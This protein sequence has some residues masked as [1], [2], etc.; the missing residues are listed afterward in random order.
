MSSLS[1]I[2]PALGQ[3]L[4][5][6]ARNLSFDYD[7]VR[8][9]SDLTIAVP[10]GEMFGF[11]GPNG[12]GKSTVLSLLAGLYTPLAGS[13]CVL[14]RSPDHRLRSR[15]GVLFQDSCLDS[16]M[17]VSETLRLQGK[18]FGLFGP[19]L[20][21][22][23]GEVLAVVDLSDR[24][25]DYVGHL[26]GGMKRRLELARSLLPSPS[27]LLLDEPT[28]GLDPE[29]KARLWSYLL[30]INREGRTMVVS[31]NDVQEAERY[32]R[33]VALLHKGCLVAMGT[34][35]ELKRELHRD[36]VLVEWPDLDEEKRREI[37]DWPGV[38]RV[39]WSPPF[40]HLTVDGASSFVP[41]LFQ[42]VGVGNGAAGHAIQ[43]IRIRESTLEDAY[44]Q[45]V[46]SPIA[47][48]VHGR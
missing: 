25:G 46:G 8:A 48:D 32:F 43:G 40:L 33:L 23:V 27:L 20:S 1:E 34:P 38:G 13:L 14:G 3:S 36:S 7:G 17:T 10:D 39:T 45:L 37:A 42:S 41:R 21:R 28:V 9:L 5:V 47:Q 22:R 29:A 11:L 24:G 4:A 26:S 2:C 44:F 30:Q 6:D 15:V 19:S 18:M 12:S 31:T 35:A 16:L